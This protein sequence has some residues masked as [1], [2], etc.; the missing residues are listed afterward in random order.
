MTESNRMRLTYPIVGENFKD[1]LGFVHGLPVGTAIV[2]ER[3]PTNP[4]DPNAVKVVVGDRHVGYIKATHALPLA[5]RID[6]SDAPTMSAKLV[7]RGTR[8]TGCHFA[9]IE[10]PAA[11]NLLA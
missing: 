2:L 6:R 5:A 9:E 11:E 1:A 4:Y 10:L 3:E 7:R 8:G